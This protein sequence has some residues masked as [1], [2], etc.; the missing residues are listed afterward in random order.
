M[1]S[2]AGSGVK[3]NIFFPAG[4]FIVNSSFL[5]RSAHTDLL[6][7]ASSTICPSLTVFPAGSQ[8]SS[9]VATFLLKRHQAVRVRAPGQLAE[10][11]SRMLQR[12]ES[13][14]SQ[15]G[16]DHP[17]RGNKKQKPANRRVER[18]LTLSADRGVASG[19]NILTTSKMSVYINTQNHRTIS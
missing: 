16:A 15:S 4:A 7:W 5:L 6:L 18:V 17:N 2:I 12:R 9:S 19:Q 3:G 8:G 11:E 1:T 10:R 14:S 13:G